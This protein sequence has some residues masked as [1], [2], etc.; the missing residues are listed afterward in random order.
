[1]AAPR[2]APL[3]SWL[4]PLE[5][6]VLR[7]AHEVQL[8]AAL[9]P[10]DA[11][12]ER[13]RMTE[14][15]RAGR[16]PVPRWT[17]VATS[18]DDL[19]RA[20]DAAERVLARDAAGGVERLYLERVRELVVE[21]DLCAA[22]GTPA[23]AALARERFDAK[24][25]A[26][27]RAASDTAASWIAVRRPTTNGDTIASDSDDPR[28]LLSRMRAAVGEKRLPFAVVA[29]P[30]L[31]PLAATGER[32]ILVAVG[33]RVTDEDVERTVLHEIEG[34]VLPRARAACAPL[35]LFAA[36]TARGVDDQEGR[37]LLLE[38]RA[39]LL[40]PRRRAQLAARHVAFETMTA[41]ATFTDVSTA[42]VRDHG[43][44]PVDA[45]IAAERVFRGSDGTHAGLGRERIYLEALS[46]VRSW[47]AAHPEDEPV[48]ASGQIAAH[49]T[50]E[51]RG[52]IV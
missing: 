18:N 22:A 11:H 50:P 37:A 14:E 43:V 28:S 13:A 30:T 20:L 36:A 41:G 2:A 5:R 17:Y 42:L 39:G 10:A 24:D 15:L 35:A 47:L 52:F 34:H 40:G 46:R 48:M 6:L 44:D 9:T 12:R 51:L 32:T 31:A 7:A 19:R 26:V 8:L 25:P 45:I 38:D 21:S 4:A 27:T 33:R 3:P 16:A 1:M 49:A 23:V 29:Q